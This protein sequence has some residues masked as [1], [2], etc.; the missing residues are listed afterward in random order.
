MDWRVVGA[1]LTTSVGFILGW[2]EFGT[3]GGAVVSAVLVSGCFLVSIFFDRYVY[4][5]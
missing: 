5:F 3:L 4:R 2:V 1:G